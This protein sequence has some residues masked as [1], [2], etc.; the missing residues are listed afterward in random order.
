METQN[1][2]MNLLGGIDSEDCGFL[3]DFSHIL[4]YRVILLIID[5][6]NPAD[7]LIQPNYFVSCNLIYIFKFLCIEHNYF[8]QFHIVKSLSYACTQGSYPFFKFNINEEENRTNKDAEKTLPNLKVHDKYEIYN[9]KFYDFFL[10]L[11]TKIILISD[12]ENNNSN[13][14]HPNPFLFDLFSS[15]LDLLIE[16]IQGSKPELLSILFDNIDEKIVDILGKDFEAEKYK[17]NESFEVFIKNVVKIVFEE[18]YDLKL[19]NEIKNCLMHYFTSILEEKNCN[20][21]MKKFIKKYINV[22]NIYAH[23]IKIMK[24]YFL[25]KQK[26]IKFEKIKNQIAD[27][28]PNKDIIHKA[29]RATHIKRNSFISPISRPRIP[30]FPKSMRKNNKDILESS[31]SNMALINTIIDANKDLKNQLLALNLQKDKQENE[32]FKKIFSNEK[33]VS[34]YSLKEVRTFKEEIN[35]N[36]SIALELQIS[37]ITFGKKLYDFFRKQFYEDPNFLE[38][39]EFKLI[40]SFY[41]FIKIKT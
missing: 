16:I 15:I 12:W 1:E 27:L 22:N 14:F 37:K 5:F 41:K 33:N 4:F 26:P 38:T 9:I 10:F 40:N 2:L 30:A 24:I 29:G 3:E 25:N 11:L 20:E 21:T 32:H 39:L 19:I 7:K 13:N 36:N 28:I 17:K 31:S 8:F 34:K 18:K 6:L 35:N 23:I